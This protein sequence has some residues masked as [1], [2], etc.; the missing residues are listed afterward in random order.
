MHGR[1][2]SLVPRPFF[3]YNGWGFFKSVVKEK[4]TYLV[5]SVLCGYLS[6]MQSVGKGNQTKKSELVPYLYPRQMEVKIQTTH[7][8]SSHHCE[9]SLR[10]PQCSSLKV[11]TTVVLALSNTYTTSSHKFAM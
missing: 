1:G 7:L 3:S 8:I 10:I 6:R 11:C 2:S 9:C 4:S 5:S